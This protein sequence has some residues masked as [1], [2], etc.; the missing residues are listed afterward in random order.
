MC[1][2]IRLDTGQPKLDNSYDFTYSDGKTE[3]PSLTPYHFVFQATLDGKEG[4]LEAGYP[5]VEAK[6]DGAVISLRFPKFDQ[7]SYEVLIRQDKRTPEQAEQDQK[8]SGNQSVVLGFLI[9][10]LCLLHKL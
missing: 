1:R 3:S 10:L 7:A 5:K 6:E 4:K 2:N 9:C 8:N